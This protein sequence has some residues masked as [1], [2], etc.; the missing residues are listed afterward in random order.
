[1]RIY[2]QL[3]KAWTLALLVLA[4]R[5]STTPTI[6]PPTTAVTGPQLAYVELS[7]ESSAIWMVDSTGA[8][9]QLSPSGGWDQDPAWSPD[10]STIAF[11]SRQNDGT[12]DIYTM[13]ASG[14][15]RVR[16]TTGQTENSRPAWSHDSKRIAFV[17][18]RDGNSEIYVMSADGSQQSRLTFRDDAFDTKPAWS[19]D[20]TRIAFATEGANGGI[21][22]INADGTE[23]LQL[24]SNSIDS[25]PAWSPDGSRI[26]FSSNSDGNYDRIFVVNADGS[27]RAPYSPYGFRAADPTWSPDGTRIAFVATEISDCTDIWECPLPSVRIFIRSPE[28]VIYSM[29]TNDQYP[30]DPA[31]RP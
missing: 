9:V 28:G 30:N 24:T 22:V 27:G 21:F 18:S 17:S 5:E 20:G 11:T 31:W 6:A 2:P 1:M 4:C 16:L 14:A 12:S 7:G 26:A 25:A 19:P 23:T 13:S 3:P 8:R 15:N 29:P 10:G